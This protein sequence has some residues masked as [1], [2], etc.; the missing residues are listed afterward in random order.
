MRTIRL[1]KDWSGD[2]SSVVG[3]VSLTDEFLRFLES[4]PTGAKLDFEMLKRPDG[5]AEILAARITP[6]PSL[7]VIE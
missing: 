5:T 4:V 3:S 2:V 6:K 7:P 1:V